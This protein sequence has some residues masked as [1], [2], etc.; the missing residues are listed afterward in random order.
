TLGGGK[1]QNH[2]GGVLL[3]GEYVY[4][5]HGSNN[6]LP[7]CVELRTGRVVWK[8]RGPG[9]GSAAVVYAD[10]CLYFRYQNGVV[11]LIEASAGG[12]HL[13][14]TLRIPGAGGDSWAHPVVAGSRLYLREQDRLWVYD[15]RR[16]S[17]TPPTAP[18]RPPPVRDA[19]ASALRTLGIGVEPLSAARPERARRF[20][21]YAADNEMPAS[22]L[23]IA[24]ADKHLTSQG[25]VPPAVL[26]ALKKLR[27]PFILN[28]AGTHVRDAGLE[29]LRALERV[30]GI[31]LELCGDLTD[32]GLAWLQPLPHLRVL[33]LAGTSVTATGLKALAP[34]K[35]LVALDLEVCDGIS[36]AGCET[37][38]AM[39]QLKALVL[40]KTGF[41]PQR[42][43]DAG[44]RRLST[45]HQMELLDLYGNRVSDAGLVHLQGMH[46]LRELNLS[47][48]AITDG[49][50]AHLKPLKRLERLELL[51]S[52]GFAGP[53]IT[54]A[55]LSSLKPLMNLNV[56]N[57]TGA[58]VTD[59]GLGNLRSLTK[60]KLLELVNTGAT[61]EGIRAMKEA[62]PGCNIVK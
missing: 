57:L 1:F 4:G 12:Y 54:N 8:E 38:G 5:G 6:G 58:R 41:E 19:A 25:T 23:L 14:G 29:Q 20:Y 10:G 27:S 51:Y 42:I 18:T 34:N 43:S 52:E 33:I 49:G 22:T 26:D 15:L 28:L 59:A 40:K 31:N 53:L 9:V 17:L 36:D 16:D 3:L 45:L 46:E 11:A 37:L 56:L 47:L 61:T 30:V 13:K 62:L 7:T 48:L 60:L 35:S 2:H 44:L 50:L 32:A 21:G 55:G 39:R 24:L